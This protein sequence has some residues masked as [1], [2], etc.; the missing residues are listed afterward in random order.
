VQLLVKESTLDVLKDLLFC[1][2]KGYIINNPLKIK[3]LKLKLLFNSF[4]NDNLFSD[5]FN[6]TFMTNTNNK[7]N[8][9]AFAFTTDNKVAV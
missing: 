7:P 2:K 1:R 6:G 4:N 9:A 3:V 5:R 8:L